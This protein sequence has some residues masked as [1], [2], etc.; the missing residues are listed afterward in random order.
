[1]GMLFQNKSKVTSKFPLLGDLPLIGGL[2]RHT[3]TVDSNN[4]L[5]V[6]ITP[7]VMDENRSPESS[8]QLN[9]SLETLETIK[10]QLAPAPQENEEE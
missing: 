3:K 2:F 10:T 7:Y 8:E 5:L 9:D 6:F 1:M 4:E